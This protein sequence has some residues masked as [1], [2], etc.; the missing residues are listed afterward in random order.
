MALSCSNTRQ[1]WEYQDSTGVDRYQVVRYR[2][3]SAAPFIFQVP[4]LALYLALFLVPMLAWSQGTYT[5]NFPLT[6]NPISEGGRWI[7]GGVTGLDWANVQTTGGFA[8]GVGPASAAYADPSAV[9][10]GNWGPNQTLTGTVYSVGASDSYYQEVELRLRTTIS[11]HSI[12]GYEVNFRTPN[13][14]SA[15]VYIVRWNGAVGNFTNLAWATGTGVSNGDVVKATIV[16]NTIS[17]YI[18]GT[19]MVTA[20][21]STYATG[22]PGIGFDYGCANTYSAF[23][24]TSF[25]ATDGTAQTPNFT[26]SATPASQTVTPGTNAAYTVNVAPSGGFTGT[27][28]LRAS[29]LPTGATASFN[30]SSVTTSGSSTLTVTT[31][32]STAA[33]SYP[34]TI[35]GTSGTLSQTATPTLVVSGSS[36]TGGTTGASACDVNKDGLVNVVDVQVA[37]DNDVSCSTSPFATFYSQVV[38]GV[39][40]SCPVTSGLHT[41]SL[42]WAAS[43]TSGV[44][45]NVYRATTSG[46][47]NYNAPLNS[48]PI[49]GTSF[50]DCTVT[51]GQVYYYVI[52][53]VDGSGNQSANST[54]STVSVPST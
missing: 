3:R 2:G 23:G 44:T 5:T 36:G 49:S 6:E 22:N 42:S 1:T 24:F 38:T 14:G 34:I 37:A 9:L 43:T 29:G 51:L 19:L 40:T 25:T 26:M 8:G 45:Y 39:L 27:V 46:G 53:S 47:Y 35:T 15:Y 50:S 10:A 52:R 11:A 18:N 17:A 31:A 28:S 32:T 4:R 33:S 12:T 13:N 30:P 7:N 21:D 16:G 48:A 41:V 54:E 20:T